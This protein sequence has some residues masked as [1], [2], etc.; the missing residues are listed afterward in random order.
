[1]FLCVCNMRAMRTR[2]M[3]SLCLRDSF[4]YSCSVGPVSELYNHVHSF[5]MSENYLFIEGTQNSEEEK[6]LKAIKSVMECFC[7]ALK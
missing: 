4:L 1:M 5:P 3:N 2:K 7:L 6:W